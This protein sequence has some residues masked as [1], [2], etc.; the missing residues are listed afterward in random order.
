MG[1]KTSEITIGETAET[2]DITIECG[3]RFFWSL[4]INVPDDVEGTLPG[5][6]SSQSVTR[7]FMQIRSNIAGQGI[8][9]LSLD[10]IGENPAITVDGSDQSRI[11]IE[12]DISA[13]ETAAL[14]LGGAISA[15]SGARSVASALYDTYVVTNDGE[16]YRYAQGNAVISPRISEVEIA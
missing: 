2:I 1:V 4:V 10:S 3:A 15:A 7:C 12:I 13:A 9:Y 14:V 6:T 8:T 11:T 5:W 16:Y